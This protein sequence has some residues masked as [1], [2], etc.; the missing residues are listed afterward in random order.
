MSA[1]SNPG[2]GPSEE[3]DPE[4]RARNALRALQHSLAK[5]EAYSALLVRNSWR[6]SQ[7]LQGSDARDSDVGPTLSHATCGSYSEVLSDLGR[8]LNTTVN[9]EIVRLRGFRDDAEAA[10]FDFDRYVDELNRPM[11]YFNPYEMFPG[12]YALE[13]LIH[14][15]DIVLHH[16]RPGRDFYAPSYLINSHYERV[17]ERNWKD[18]SRAPDVPPPGKRPKPD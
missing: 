5:V 15:A 2:P 3:K 12:L 11:A 6:S 9:N 4:K 14:Q 7:F 10:R 1:P 18:G 17:L 13:G 8:V 16:H